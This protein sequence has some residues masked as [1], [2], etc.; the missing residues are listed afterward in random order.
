MR[1][2]VP[3]SLVLGLAVTSF[4]CGAA[5]IACPSQLEVTALAPE[6]PGWQTLNRARSG[7]PLE[8]I[9]VRRAAD[10]VEGIPQTGFLRMEQGARKTILA[11]WD[12][13]ET[14]AVNPVLWLVCVYA[15]T[16]I[17]LVREL[18][19]EAMSCEYRV[20]S[21]DTRLEETAICR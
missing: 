3:L 18:P 17:T 10:S 4:A 7:V 15:G 1:L 9:E 14:R 6:I 5:E 16:T 20:E 13:T 21:T 11:R 8:R 12:L 2:L 19:L